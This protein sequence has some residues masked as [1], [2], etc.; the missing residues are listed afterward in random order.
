M[1]LVCFVSVVWLILYSCSLFVCLF[2]LYVFG[3]VVY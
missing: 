1:F 2:C 3:V